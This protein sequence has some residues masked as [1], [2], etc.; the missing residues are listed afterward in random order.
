[1]LREIDN[2]LGELNRKAKQGKGVTLRVEDVR[3]I[4]RASRAF[5]NLQAGPGIKLTR[6]K[7]TMRIELS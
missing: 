5:N 6:S 1:M 2:L 3:L 7:G 4:L